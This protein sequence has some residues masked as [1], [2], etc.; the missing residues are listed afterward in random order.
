MSE[1][2]AAVSAVP[3]A[4]SAQALPPAATFA[5]PTQ[6]MINKL[7][8]NEAVVLHQL[9]TMIQ[10]SGKKRVQITYADWL[11]RFPFKSE[12]TL[13]RTIRKLEKQD[14]I[15]SRRLM[16]RFQRIKEYWVE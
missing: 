10:E 16:V 6:E 9:Q 5:N 1:I 15:Q 14:I 11:K 7:G 13:R 2:L 12:E 3:S 8:Y 4:P